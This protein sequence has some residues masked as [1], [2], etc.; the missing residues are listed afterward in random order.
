MAP[1]REWVAQLQLHPHNPDASVPGICPSWYSHS[2]YPM[3][4]SRGIEAKMTYS[5]KPTARSS[6]PQW[7]EEPRSANAWE[8]V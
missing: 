4:A 3:N 7:D 8:V 1:S 5:P 2:A 6:S